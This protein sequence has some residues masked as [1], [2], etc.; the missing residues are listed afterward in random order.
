MAE[1]HATKEARRA[2]GRKGGKQKSSNAKA[3]LKQRSSKGL[4]KPKQTLPI[5]EEK[6]RE[7]ETREEKRSVPS[8]EGLRLAGLLREAVLKWKADAKTPEDLTVW[9][10]DIDRMI[11]LDKRD[12]D[13]VEA[14]IKWLPTDTFW[15]PNILSGLKLREK[16]DK[17]E[18]KMNERQNRQPDAV[19]Q[20]EQKRHPM[21][22]DRSLLNG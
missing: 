11:R 10:R 1:W 12:P 14:V 18:T 4:A 3:K 13:C 21:A 22:I 9:S 16:F 2:A 7:D 19:K 8:G 17:L 20:P 15:P 6:I 5:R